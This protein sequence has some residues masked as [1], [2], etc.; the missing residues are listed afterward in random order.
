MACVHVF[1][2]VR[3]YERACAFA[4]AP[5]PRSVS[6]AA[7]RAAA[8]RVKRNVRLSKDMAATSAYLMNFC[9]FVFKLMYVIRV[10]PCTLN[11][12]LSQ[13]QPRPVTSTVE[14][15]VVKSQALLRPT[16]TD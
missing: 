3:A 4:H 1:A 2:S 7:A 11:W 15:R 14:P 6:L 8:L 10:L 9:F 13:Q 16:K 5:D 12:Y